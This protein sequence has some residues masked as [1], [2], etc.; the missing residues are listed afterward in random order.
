MLLLLLLSTTGSFSLGICSAQHLWSQPASSVC[1]RR[2]RRGYRGPAETA[3]A[4]GED[5][6]TA[7]RHPGQDIYLHAC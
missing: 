1:R 6:G 3:H 4:G 2:H 5:V 7:G